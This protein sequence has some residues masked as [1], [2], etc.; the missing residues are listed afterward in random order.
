MS[1]NEIDC[2]YYDKNE[3]SCALRSSYFPTGRIVAVCKGN[4]CQDK[5]PR[6]RLSTPPQTGKYIRLGEPKLEIQKNF[7]AGKYEEKH[8]F[9]VL[10]KINDFKDKVV[11]DEIV[12]FAQEQGITDL[13]LIDE[14]FVKS[15]LI[16]ENELRSPVHQFKAIK[17]PPTNYDRITESAEAFADWIFKSYTNVPENV[18]CAVENCET[19]DRMDC[20]KCFIKWLQKEADDGI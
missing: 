13:F 5:T 2:M 14:D 7:E 8:V 19:T 15:A 6:H 1:V 4:A 20:K 3:N 9:K 12:R 18:P 10:A 17:R 16:H 11:Y